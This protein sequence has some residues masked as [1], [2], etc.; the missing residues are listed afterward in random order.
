MRNLRVCLRPKAMSHP[1]WDPGGRGQTPPIYYEPT[2]H[3]T[4]VEQAKHRRRAYGMHSTSD[5]R[6]ID[7]RRLTGSISRIG[8]GEAYWRR[9]VQS[10]EWN[11]LSNAHSNCSKNRIVLPSDELSNCAS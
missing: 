3:T 8:A 11:V 6:L 2:K 7:T 5:V 10:L 4:G 9:R 1:R